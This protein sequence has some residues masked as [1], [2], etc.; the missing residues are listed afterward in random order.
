MAA[1]L[2]SLKR[3]FDVFVANLLLEGHEDTVILLGEL[4]ATLI[5]EGLD[6]L[7]LCIVLILVLD[8]FFESAA[9]LGGS[10]SGEGTGLAGSGRHKKRAHGHGPTSGSKTAG[11]THNTLKR[12]FGEHSLR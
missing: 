12:L 9:K 3:H 2:P 8:L 6:V 7:K 5:K 4:E 1:H 10:I 11:A